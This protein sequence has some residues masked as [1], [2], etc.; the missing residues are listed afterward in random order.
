MLRDWRDPS[1][2]LII[3][4]VVNWEPATTVCFILKPRLCITLACNLSGVQPRRG[5]AK[6]IQRLLSMEGRQL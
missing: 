1:G 4:N 6:V 5:R 2:R 3:S